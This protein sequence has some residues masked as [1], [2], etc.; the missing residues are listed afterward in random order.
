MLNTIVFLMLDIKKENRK[1]SQHCSY[2]VLCCRVLTFELCQCPPRIKNKQY[3]NGVRERDRWSERKQ[4]TRVIE[5]RCQW[6]D[7]YSNKIH[8]HLVVLQ[9]ASE[10]ELY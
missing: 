4:E 6:G 8:D 10:A 1:I 2:S 3:K 9:V 5:R 7:I